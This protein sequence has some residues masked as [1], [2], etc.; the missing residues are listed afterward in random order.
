MDAVSQALQQQI[1]AQEELNEAMETY[2]SIT[3][4]LSAAIDSISGKGTTTTQAGFNTLFGQAMGGDT[5]AL[6]ALPGAATTFLA[7][8]YE[9]SETELEYRRLQSQIL[10]KLGQAETFSSNQLALLDASIP[11]HATGLSS[12]PYDGYLMRA[13]KDEAVLT[14]P[15]AAEWRKSKGS[16]VT[17]LEGFKE[18]KEELK[19]LRGVM[20]A[21]IYQIA[22]NT[23]KTKDILTRFDDDGIPAERII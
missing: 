11:G 2:T 12:V 10:N 23:G 18:L 22:K 15:E 16:N 9:M 5:E 8:A 19:A 1:W 7:A 21:G 3:E 6:A 17:S 4:A 20:E 14:A 13:H